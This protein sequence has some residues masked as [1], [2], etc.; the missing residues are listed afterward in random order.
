MVTK[1]NP[2][3]PKKSLSQNFLHSESHLS[4][5]AKLCI[6]EGIKMIE[7][8]PGRGALTKKVLELT[9]DNLYAIEIDARL[10]NDLEDL[11]ANFPNFEYKI[12][13]FLKS[14]VDVENKIVFG[15]LPYAS[16]SKMLL[17]ILPKKGKKLVFLFQKEVVERICASPSTSEYGSFSV[18]VQAYYLPKKGSV[19]SSGCFF[20]R[21][22]VNS[23]VVILQKKDQKDI[24]DHQKLLN[25]LWIAFKFKRKKLRNGLYKEWPKCEEFVDLDKRPEEIEVSK[26]IEMCRVF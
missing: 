18:L 15:N 26:Y 19:I 25:L 12:G 13:D 3:A 11:K 4:Q 2:I 5:I 14:E 9:K 8:G 20:P 21:P 7:I 16:A 10:E 23:Q 17:Q 1:K 6:E 24:F 22:K